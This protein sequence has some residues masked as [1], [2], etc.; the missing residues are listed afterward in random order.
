MPR[1]LL[2][3]S[4][5]IAENIPEAKG[6]QARA[7]FKLSQLH[8]KLGDAEKSQRCGLAAKK[9]RLEIGGVAADKELAQEDYEG[10][11][12]WMLW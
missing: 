6:C 1:N 4:V 5:S 8:R 9:A 7:L 12:L 3:E 11:V 2:E 10:L